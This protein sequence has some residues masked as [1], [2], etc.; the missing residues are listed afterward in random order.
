MNIEATQ[1][2]SITASKTVDG[3]VPA[4]RMAAEKS[5]RSNPV[6]DRPSAMKNPPS[7]NQ[8]TGLDQVLR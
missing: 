6:R 1:L 4:G 3:L 8:M 7:I 2:V 5:S